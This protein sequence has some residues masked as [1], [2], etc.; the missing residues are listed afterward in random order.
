ME[1]C[2]LSSCNKY[3]VKSTG[4][5]SESGETLLSKNSELRHVLRYEKKLQDS[6]LRPNKLCITPVVVVETA[7]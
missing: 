5:I 2:A 7:L 1:L 6:P 3:T 4:G